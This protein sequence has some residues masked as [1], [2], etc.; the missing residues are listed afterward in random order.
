M[1]A[2]LGLLALIACFTLSLI[3]SPSLLA[4]PDNAVAMAGQVSSAEEGPM[5]GVLV[6][7]RRAGSNV[8][9]T[10]VSDNAVHVLGGKQSRRLDRETGTAG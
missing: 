5:E 2:G 9:I 10:V 6:S 3:F 7:A 8:T 1:K 4:Q